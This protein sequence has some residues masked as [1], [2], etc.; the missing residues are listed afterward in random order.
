MWL[1][2]PAEKL[3]S[4]KAIAIALIEQECDRSMCVI[5]QD[6]VTEIVVH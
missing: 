5:T 1:S 2:I 6:F 4:L 3:K